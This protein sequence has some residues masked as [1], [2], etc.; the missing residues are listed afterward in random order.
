MATMGNVPHLIG[1][2]MTTRSWHKPHHN[3]LKLSFHPKKGASKLKNSPCFKHKRLYIN[4]L[5]W[6]DPRHNH[7]ALQAKCACCA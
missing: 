1:N 5:A 7:K 3:P 6:F 2:M 4:H